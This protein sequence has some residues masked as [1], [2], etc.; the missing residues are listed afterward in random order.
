MDDLK[1]VILALLDENTE[2]VTIKKR[3][4]DNNSQNADTKGVL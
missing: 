4:A 3:V 2:I 1:R